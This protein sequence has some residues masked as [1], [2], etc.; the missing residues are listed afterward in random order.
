MDSNVESEPGL[1]LE[2]WLSGRAVSWTV[3]VSFITAR[4]LDRSKFVT[5][6]DGIA[7]TEC[8]CTPLSKSCILRNGHI[9]AT[10]LQP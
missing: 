3:A 8:H 9:Q 2:K 5:N 6:F 7:Y 10:S 1:G 4:E